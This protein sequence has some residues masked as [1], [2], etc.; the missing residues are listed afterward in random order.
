MYFLWSVY[1]NTRFLVGSSLSVSIIPGDVGKLNPNLDDKHGGEII[2]KFA[3]AIDVIY[4][5]GLCLKE[6]LSALE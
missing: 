6:V 1:I 4:P 3:N 5:L 2:S